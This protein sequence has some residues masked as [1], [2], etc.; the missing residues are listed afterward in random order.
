MVLKQMAYTGIFTCSARAFPILID[1]I[2][3]LIAY[4]VSKGSDEPSVRVYV[5]VCVCVWGGGGG[6]SDIFIN[7]RL[8]PFFLSKILNFNIFGVFRK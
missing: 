3:K 4:A 8:G 7:R 5:C 6:Y 1:G 2:L